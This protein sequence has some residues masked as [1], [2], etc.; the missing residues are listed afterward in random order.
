MSSCKFSIAALVLYCTAFSLLAAPDLTI[1]RGSGSGG[2]AATTVPISGLLD[3]TKENSISNGNHSQTW[4]WALTNNANALKLYDTGVGTN[5]GNWL[6]VIDTGPTSIVHAINVNVRGFPVFDTNTETNQLLMGLGNVNWP[7]LSQGTYTNT[8]I[9]FPANEMAISVGG[10]QK[11]TFTTN[12]VEATTYWNNQYANTSISNL[13][14][15]LTNGN[16]Q[17][18]TITNDSF[19]S[20]TGF[21]GKAWAGILHVVQGPAGGSIL[22]YDTNGLWKPSTTTMSF[23]TN[24]N[25]V[26]TL[27]LVTGPAMTNLHVVPGFTYGP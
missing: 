16:V 25:A 2:G 6:F 12:G 8:G 19:L 14:V 26:D 9:Y 4:L 24:A 13:V 3:A 10:V 15:N 5:S 22:T 7:I 11:A 17:T 20:F 21:T 23:T 18:V 27:Y 1:R